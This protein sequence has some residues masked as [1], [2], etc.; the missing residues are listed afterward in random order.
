MYTHKQAIEAIQARINGNF[1]NF[2]LMRLGPLTTST[3]DDILR[4]CS[5]IE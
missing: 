3:L 4:I 5:N 1:N 2:Q